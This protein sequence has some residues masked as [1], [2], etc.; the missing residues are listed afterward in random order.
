MLLR[1]ISV[2]AARLATYRMNETGPSAIAPSLKGL[3]RTTDDHK[4]PQLTNCVR[5]KTYDRNH[6]RRQRSRN[7]TRNAVGGCRCRPCERPPTGPE[8]PVW[9]RHH[10]R[11][12]GGCQ[13]GRAAAQQAGGVKT[14]L[15]HDRCGT[16]RMPL[17]SGVF[18]VYLELPGST[19]QDHITKVEVRERTGLPS[20]SET[21]SRRRMSMLGHMSRMPPSAD[22]YK[23]IYTLSLIHI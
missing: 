2:S 14:G 12:R 13:T 11:P 6:P 15:F 7:S 21:I 1:F 17:I 4:A 5:P 23:A 8:G 19:W 22:A 20:V 18:D 10:G 3:R 16:F 9:R